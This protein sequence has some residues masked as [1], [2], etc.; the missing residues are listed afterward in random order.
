MSFEY[1][2]RTLD[3]CLKTTKTPT[4]S[5]TTTSPEQLGLPHVADA[6]A[7]HIMSFVA[8]LIFMEMIVCCG[9]SRVATSALVVKMPPTV[10]RF[11]GNSALKLCIR[12]PRPA[13][14]DPSAQ[15]N[16]LRCAR[17]K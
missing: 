13:A 12:Q 16:L 6:A 3:V 15:A 4:V 1:I 5:I 11:V 9:P 10:P 2:E 8:F 7:V 17:V 14:V